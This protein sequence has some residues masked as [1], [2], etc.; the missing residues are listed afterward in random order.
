MK[1]ADKHVTEHVAEKVVRDVSD[2][3]QGGG[4]LADPPVALDAFGV[5]DVPSSDP[6]RQRHVFPL[7]EGTLQ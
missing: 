6:V 7:P 2:L 5:P 3:Q 4:Q 1:D